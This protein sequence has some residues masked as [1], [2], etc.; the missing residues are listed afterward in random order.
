MKSILAVMGFES[1]LIIRNFLVIFFGALFPVGLITLFGYVFGNEP[2]EQW[3]GYGMI[4]VSL[5]AYLGIGLAVCGV[6]SFPLTIA[7]YRERKVLKRFKAT[8]LSPFTILGVQFCLNAFLAV[9]STLLMFFVA[10]ALFDYTFQGSFLHFIAF[11][12]LTLLSIFSIGMII[13]SV[14]KKERTAE[15]MATMIFFVLIF[16]SGSTIPFEILPLPLQKVLAIIPLTHG[17]KLLK[18]ASLGLE[19]SSAYSSVLVLSAITLAG[20]AIALF[21]FKWE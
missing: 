8:P 20:A 4:D 15:I 1:R 16:L 6:Q 5:P 21:T 18:M 9:I 10:K 3:G 12:L 13:A 14:A 2:S 19:M 17:I 11:Y 7:H